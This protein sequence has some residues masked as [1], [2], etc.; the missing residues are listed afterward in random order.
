M[1]GEREIR[2]GR[3]ICIVSGHRFI[4]SSGGVERVLVN[5]SNE[6]YR[7]GDKVTLLCAEN[8]TGVP[9][10]PLD[11]GVSFYNTK[12]NKM[13]EL[14]QR[15]RSGFIKDRAE[16]K[17]KRAKRISR[18]KY[19]RI[20]AYIEKE[21]PDIIISSRPIVTYALKEIFHSRVP[22]I[23]MIHGEPGHVFDEHKGAEFKKCLDYVQVLSPKFAEITEK[24]LGNGYVTYIPN[25]V[26][27]TEKTVDYS[28]KRILTVG[29]IERE[30]RIL[31]LIQAF[32]RISRRYPDW[33]LEIWGD[34]TLE[35][36]YYRLC[37]DEVDILQ[38]K[39]KIKFC[40]MTHDIERTLQNGS[41][42]AFPSPSE[43][44]PLAL[45]EAMSM[46]FPVL[47][48]ETC[49]GVNEIIENGGNGLLAEDT[50]ESFAQALET[51]IS[52]EQLR[53]NL[54]EC[55]KESMKRYAPEIVWKQWE[56]LIEKVRK[57]K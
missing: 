53:K 28:K 57:T 8:K 27:P 9:F 2:M 12:Y 19:S 49:S 3:K 42:F 56:D 54:G 16:R 15:I 26:F 22:V 25:A 1:R 18:I 23:T 47:G 11:E 24:I 48:I 40:G 43:G 14:F 55:A 50:T 17:R 5:L 31:F 30:K 39:E 34:Y 41:I 44:F 20:A 51:L 7:R 46:G 37:C 29:R 6:L 35:P 13:S 10:Y 38:L 52:H 32:S 4:K 21:N 45:T 36:E 33:H